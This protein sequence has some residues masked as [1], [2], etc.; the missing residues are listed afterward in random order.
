[1]NAVWNVANL[2]FRQINP[3]HLDEKTKSPNS[4]AFMPTPK[5]DNQL[6]VDDASLTT[7]E[8]AWK[9][10][11][12]SLG[13]Q[14]AGTWAVSYGEVNAAG[15]LDV[16]SDP[17]VNV[18]DLTKNNPAHCLIDFT[19]ITTKG[20]QRKR[21]QCLALAATMRGCMFQPTFSSP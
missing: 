21:A 20:Q 17:I 1:M 15:D 18:E 7:S 11:V 10:F 9:R 2:F 8:N 14:S 4:V 19:K 13:F 6:S 3:R 16:R 12:E 5:D